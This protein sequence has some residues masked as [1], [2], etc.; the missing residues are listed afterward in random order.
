MVED[1]LFTGSGLSLLEL[2]KECDFPPTAYLLLE[3]LP[4]RVLREDERDERQN[5]IYFAPFGDFKAIDEKIDIASYSSGR[6]FDEEGELRWEQDPQTGMTN[7][8][9]LGKA[10][11]FTK[12]T[13][14]KDEL[15]KLKAVSNNP[16]HFYLFGQ[17]LSEQDN[18]QMGIV[19]EPEQAYYAE[20]RIPRLL[21]Y[22]RLKLE[23]KLPQRLKL[24]VY[25]YVDQ[26]TGRV[27]LFR[28][29]GLQPAE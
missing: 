7:A 24:K 2:I 10:R 3:K 25:E 20:V 6:I 22:P 12:L 9:Y 17:L 15:S 4:Q 29:Q 8:V 23:A 1:I 13:Q 21:V 27:K 16:K 26:D 28:F 18:E 14:V 5:L 11:T 19:A